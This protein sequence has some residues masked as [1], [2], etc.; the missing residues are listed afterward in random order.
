MPLTVGPFLSAGNCLATQE[1]KDDMAGKP[2]RELVSAL[3]WLVLGSQPDIAFATGT[4]A[5]FSHN[6]GR[7][8][9]EAAVNQLDN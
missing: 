2:Y 5:R 1:E 6:L 3:S 4:L 8:H 7:A 9:W